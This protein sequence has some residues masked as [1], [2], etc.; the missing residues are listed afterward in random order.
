M[1]GLMRSYLELVS[2]QEEKEL[3]DLLSDT[4]DIEALSSSLNL[5]LSDLETVDLI[6]N[7]I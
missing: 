5:K 6:S 3:E 7:N 2:P 1:I 4:A